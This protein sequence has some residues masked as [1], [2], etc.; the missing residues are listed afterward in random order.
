MINNLLSCIGEQSDQSKASGIASLPP[1]ARSLTKHYSED[2]IAAAIA[3]LRPPEEVMTPR[4]MRL[5]KASALSFTHGLIDRMCDE[6]WTFDRT[7]CDIQADGSGLLVYRISA[8]GR[9]LTFAISSPPLESVERAGRIMESQLDFYAGLYDGD[10]DMSYILRNAA[11]QAAKVWKG[12]SDNRTLGW[13]FANRSN[14]LFGY[15]IQTL[16]GGQQPDLAEISKLGG[17]IFRNAGFYGNGRH[18][19]RSWVSLDKAHPLSGPY[20]MDLL[21][22]YLWRLA[23][24]DYVDALARHADSASARLEPSIKR[25]IGVGNSTG[26]GMVAAIVRWPHWLSGF[27]FAREMVLALARIA[28]P[29]DID[30]QRIA[31]I[32]DRAARYYTETAGMVA[33][34]IEDRAA[35]GREL[36]TISDKIRAAEAEENGIGHVLDRLSNEHGASALEQVRSL[37]IDTR[38]DDVRIFREFVADAMSR[39]RDT[40][41]E[42]LLSELRALIRRDYAWAMAMDRSKAD[43]TRHFWYRSEDNGE[44][45]RGERG[46]DP[47]LEFET[48]IDVAGHVQSLDNRLAEC[49]AEWTTARYLVDNPDDVY[50]VS[51]VQFLRDFPYAEIHGNIIDA[52]FLPSDMI[53]Y[54]LGVLGMETAD[55][56]NFRWVRGVLMQGAPLPGEFSIPA[57]RDWTMPTFDRKVSA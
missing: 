4:F 34:H 12:R 29:A 37:I 52:S 47:G 51:R 35:I 23:S 57:C 55:P 20:H 49:P 1:Y 24:F 32:T 3:E 56:N 6:N 50:I 53:Q 14:R 39:Q 28:P 30:W 21:C 41:P 8:L 45:R 25:Y 11:E 5:I 9:L 22:L 31:R 17:Y 7:H 42:M 19:S 54:Y 33:S 16:A 38:T 18:G 44:N 46:V 10:V 13:T 15:V 43:S 40:Q 36:S 26:V 2:R 48:F 27:M